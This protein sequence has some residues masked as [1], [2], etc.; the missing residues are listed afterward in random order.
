MVTPIAVKRL[1]YHATG[2]AGD[3]KEDKN[4]IWPIQICQKQ[5]QSQFFITA[6]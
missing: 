4:Q 6:F 5:Y 3:L 1:Q 2:K